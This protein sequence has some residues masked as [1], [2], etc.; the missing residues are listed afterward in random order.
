LNLQD[1]YNFLNFFINKYT[2]NFYPP[3]E[4]DLVV[5]RGQMA[6]YTDYQPKYATSQRIKD[7]M[8]PF[9][10]VWS[11]TP[12]DTVSGVIPVPSNLSYLNLLSITVSYTISD[13][14]IYAPV[15]MVNEDEIANRL[16]SQIDPVTVTSPI[17][18]QLSPGFFRLYPLSGYTG[19]IVFLRR[20]IKPV[21]VYTTISE[22]VIVYD[23]AAS[24]QLEWA[25]TEMDSL[26]LKSLSTLGINLTDQEITQYAEVKNQQN[27]QGFNKS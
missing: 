5:D 22:R 24:T 3:D 4:L 14:T 8:A 18:E 20:P 13:R 7:A 15:Q 19:N 25:E 6:L 26:L 23:D 27:A 11:F 10:R 1:A 9:R 16:N 12:S 17:G 2:G 21:F